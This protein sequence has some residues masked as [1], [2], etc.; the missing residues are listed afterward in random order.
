[1]RHRTNFD[2]FLIPTI[3]VG[4]NDGSPR[5]RLALRKVLF[6]RSK[7]NGIFFIFRLYLEFSF[8]VGFFGFVFFL[9]GTG[10]FLIEVFR[11]FCISYPGHG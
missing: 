10:Q 5:R 6:G 4:F 9:G 1:M 7:T 8:C 3:V 11:V 2:A